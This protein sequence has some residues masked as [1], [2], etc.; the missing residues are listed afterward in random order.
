[1]AG[2]AKVIFKHG[3]FPVVH[4]L[5]VAASHMSSLLGGY[6]ARATLWL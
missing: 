1:M 5:Q 2:Q 3:P 4:G 6:A